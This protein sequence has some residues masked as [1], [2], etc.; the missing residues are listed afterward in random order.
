MQRRVFAITGFLHVGCT[1]SF[2]GRMAIVS[3]F[4]AR[5]GLAGRWCEVRMLDD[6]RN[7][8]VGALMAR[9]GQWP[10][11]YTE[12]LSYP[13]HCVTNTSAALSCPL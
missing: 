6:C 7:G 3:S 9:S 13:P 1:A 12:T 4:I 11:F 5:D 10:G 8:E 2:L